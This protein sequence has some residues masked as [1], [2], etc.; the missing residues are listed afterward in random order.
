MVETVIRKLLAS[1]AWRGTAPRDINRGRCEDF[2]QE[3]LALLGP[4]SHAREVCD[5]S[6]PEIGE[7]VSR[8]PPFGLPGHFWILHDGRHYDA[9]A[10]EGVDRWQD[11][12]IYRRTCRL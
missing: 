4:N 11:L 8:T 10:P 6:F 12:P 1:E 5:A 3:T 2:Q 7:A 9:E